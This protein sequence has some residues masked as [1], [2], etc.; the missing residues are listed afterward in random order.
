MS[1]MKK[2]KDILFD[3]EEIAEQEVVETK[4]VEKEVRKVEPVIEKIV[5][6]TRSKLE[7][8]KEVPSVFMDFDEDEFESNMP[9]VPSV[10]PQVVK[11]KKIEAVAPI[12]EAERT[13]LTTKRTEYPGYTKVETHETKE[14]R[15]FK[16]SLIISPVY[17]V[18]NEDYIP[19]DIKTEDEAINSL[20][21][22]DVRKKAYGN[23]EDM[24]KTPEKVVYE[25]K[26]TITVIPKYM[27]REKVKTIDELLQDSADNE[28][29]LSET[30]DLT[31]EI[32]FPTRKEIELDKIDV[33]ED[34]SEDTLENDLFDLIDSMYERKEEVI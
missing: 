30:L 5:S 17:G 14:K 19:E 34:T 24:G 26:E 25:Q 33:L 8:T 16:P 7:D 6:P 28:F 27:E 21:I 1:L 15:K 31:N 29:D 32:D 18:L 20:N 10:K 23:L 4:V 11:S 3:E 13:V 9:Y 12:K 2:M 22:D